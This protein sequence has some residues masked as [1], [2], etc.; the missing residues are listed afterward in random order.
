MTS[1]P[2]AAAGR[3]R[4]TRWAVAL[5]AALALALVALAVVAGRS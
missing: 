4:K 1:H 3:R 5:L 2:P